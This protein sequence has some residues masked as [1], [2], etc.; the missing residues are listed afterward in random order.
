[1]V[2][3]LIETTG[4]IVIGRGAFDLGER[5]GGWE[6]T[7]YRV[8]H[9]VVTHHPPREHPAGGVETV[10]VAGVEAAVERAREAAGDRDVAIGG[11][12]G[13]ARQCLATR[14]VDRRTVTR[15]RYRVEAPAPA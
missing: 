11:G 12:P 8:A 14:V 15:L 9:V 7:P 10:F 3:E 4:A 2:D 6:D 13:I 5:S 1:V